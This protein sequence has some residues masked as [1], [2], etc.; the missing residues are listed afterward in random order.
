MECPGGKNKTGGSVQ[1]DC[2]RTQCGMAIRPIWVGTCVCPSRGQGADQPISVIGVLSIHCAAMRAA[3]ALAVTP[4]PQHHQLVDAIGFHFRNAVRGMHGIFNKGAVLFETE[5]LPLKA[6]DMS[7]QLTFQLAEQLRLIVQG[8]TV[9][10]GAHAFEGQAVG[11][12]GFDTQNLKAVKIGIFA[13]IILGIAPWG[14][15]PRFF[16]IAQ[17]F[18]GDA[19]ALD[20]MSGG[21]V[22][23]E[24]P[25]AD[26]IE[27]RHK[28]GG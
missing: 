25:P 11:L 17:H 27:K 18:A 6:I 1:S 28:T 20:E 21:M 15:Q 8:R 22:Q 26:R 19:Q 3:P 24:S 12:Q 4:L 10:G 13:V 23:S 16:I 7:L 9:Q 14:N 5:Q 2:S